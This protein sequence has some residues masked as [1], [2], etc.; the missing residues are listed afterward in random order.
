MSR[1]YAYAVAARAGYSTAMYAEDR[2]G[3]DFRIQAGG[4]MRPALDLQLKATFN[5]GRLRMGASA[6]L[7][8]RNYDLLRIEAQTPRL[9]MV[10][11]CRETRICG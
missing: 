6:P 3:I 2:D 10:L 1:A 8:R 5:L 9:L 11:I 4:G 7:N